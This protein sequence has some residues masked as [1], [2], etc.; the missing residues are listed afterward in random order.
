MAE[1]EIPIPVATGTIWE[2]MPHHLRLINTPGRMSQGVMPVLQMAWR[3]RED[4]RIEWRTIP[5][6][7]L[8]EHEFPA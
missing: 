2:P 1:T 7:I 5:L 4:G 3:C 6:H 8:S